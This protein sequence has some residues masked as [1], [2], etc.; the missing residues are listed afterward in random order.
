MTCHPIPEIE[1]LKLLQKALYLGKQFHESYKVLSKADDPDGDLLAGMASFFDELDGA[2]ANGGQGLS[3]ESA[4]KIATKAR[5]MNTMLQEALRRRGLAQPQKK[6]DDVE[7]ADDPVE[8][9]DE[10]LEED[11][12]S[13]SQSDD[14]EVLKSLM[15]QGALLGLD[16]T[17]GMR[18]RRK[19]RTGMRIVER[20]K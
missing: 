3:Q 6:A 14:G 20:V 17:S 15:G 13:G 11:E 5:S 2:F 19:K 8:V 7:E 10:D 12:P 4:R 1:R 18:P 9:E 16:L